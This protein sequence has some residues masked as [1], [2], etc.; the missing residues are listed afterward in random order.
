M[1]TTKSA[2]A[3]FVLAMVVYPEVLQK[4]QE[5]IDRVVG[6]D[7]L[8]QLEDRDQ[9][10]YIECI[11][12]EAL[13][14]SASIPLGI[15]HCL[16]EDDEHEGH[17]IPKGST[18][19]SNIWAMTRDEE[20]DPDASTFRP[21]RFLNMDAKT[22]E[23]TDPRATVFGFG[24]R[25][26]PG[27]YF[28]DANIFMVVASMVATLNIAKARDSKGQVI[29]PSVEFHSGMTRYPPEFTCNITPRSQ[30]AEDMVSKMLTSLLD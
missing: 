21:E 28:A 6:V 7:R 24:R 25:T 11:V 15:P 3:S 1:E 12:K 5:E 20:I 16:T 18:V 2:L 9:L 17:T 14:W 29:T 23:R 30:R 10:P 22:A 13:R 27:R 26:C 8:P 4:A 19:L